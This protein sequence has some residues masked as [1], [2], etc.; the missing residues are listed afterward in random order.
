MIYKTSIV[1]E[2]GN[3]KFKIADILFIVGGLAMYY[4]MIRLQIQLF[5]RLRVK[6]EEKR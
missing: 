5:R 3:F 2:W 4:E 6:D 1:F